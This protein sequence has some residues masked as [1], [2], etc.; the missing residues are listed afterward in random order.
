MIPVL[1]LL[2]IVGVFL[3]AAAFV[4]WVVVNAVVSVYRL[5]GGRV[6]AVPDAG[7]PRCRNVGC[8]TSNPNHARFCRRCGSSLT[9]AAGVPSSPATLPLREERRPTF[10]AAT[11][12]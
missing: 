9:G 3:G 6:G 4:G 8:R 10:A 2:I 5:A 11:V 7:G 1:M 12:R